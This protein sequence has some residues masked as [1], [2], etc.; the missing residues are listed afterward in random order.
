MS[1]TNTLT[2]HTGERSSSRVDKMSGMGKNLKKMWVG[3]S[4]VFIKKFASKKRRQFLNQNNE[5]KL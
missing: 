4:K 3:A 1:K 5:E 2:S